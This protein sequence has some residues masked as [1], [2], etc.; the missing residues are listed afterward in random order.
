M[1]VTLLLM[2][3]AGCGRSAAAPPVSTVGATETPAP[4]SLAPFS[5][6]VRGQT[7]DGITCDPSLQIAYHIHAHLAVY[8]NGEPRG[9]PK[10]I[11]V[12]FGGRADVP[13]GACIYWLHSHTDDGIVHVEAPAPQTFTLG[14][15]FDI[16]GAP[17]DRTHVGPAGGTVIAY[18]DGRRYTGDVRSIPLQA[19]TLVQLDVNGN[20]SPAPFDFPLGD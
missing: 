4:P 11:G 12:L 8:V 14:E 5:D 19:H 7:V 1:L 13:G 18:V 6:A 15:Y 20:V 3:V 9:V 17:L 2:A 16:W 10:N